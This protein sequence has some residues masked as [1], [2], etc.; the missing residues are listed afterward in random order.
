MAD[1]LPNIALFC[2][3]AGKD[4]DRFLGVGGLVVTSE[5]ARAIRSEFERRKADLG[6]SAE[7]KWN[8]TRKSTL[9]KHRELVHWAFQLIQA[10][11][12]MFH[13]LLV[14]SQRFNHNLREDGGK[15]ESLK[16]MY[17]Q[18]ILHRLGKRHGKEFNLFAFPDKAN[19]LRG[20]EDMKRGLN[21]DL[22]RKHGCPP[23]CVKAIEFRESHSEPLLQLNDLILGAVVYQKNRKFD[24]EGAGHPK[25][26]LAGFVLGRSGLKDYEAETP[27]DAKWFTIW[28]FKSPHL[29]GGP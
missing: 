18:L 15:S 3:E 19:E 26:S 10:Q 25:A 14:P 27:R 24:A 22:H 29:L 4:P 9:D 21:S 8:T 16:R 5:D 23:A 1:K 2:D 17:Y 6:I 13:C 20:L 12:L 7:A 28:N 11:Q